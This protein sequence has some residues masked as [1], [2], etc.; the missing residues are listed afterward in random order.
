MKLI[1]DEAFEKSLDKI[2]DKIVKKQVKKV[3]LQ[4]EASPAIASVTNIK[5]MKGFKNLFQN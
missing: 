5:K 4:I 1:F 3:I 2:E